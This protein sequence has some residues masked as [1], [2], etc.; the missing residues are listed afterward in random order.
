[1]SASLVDKYKNAEIAVIIPAYRAELFIRRVIT[2]IPEYVKWIVVV[3]DCSPDQTSDVVSAIMDPRVI[4]I[5]HATNQG[6]GGSMWTGYQAA[7]KVGAQ[8]LVKLDADDQ[9]DTR[10]IPDLID[11]IIEGRSDYTKGN[12]FLHLSHIEAMPLIRRLGNIIL[13]FLCKIT[14]GYWS[15]FDPTNG[16][17][18]IHCDIIK[19]FVDNKVNLD[20]R[21]FFE[22]NMLIELSLLRAV[23]MDI[24]IPARYGDEV[25]SLSIPKIMVEFPVKLLKGCTRRILISY[26]VRDFG[27]FSLFLI[28]GIV[29][30]VFGGCFGLYNWIQNAMHQIPTLAGTVMVAVVP[31]ILGVQLLLQALVLDIQNSP[32]AAIHK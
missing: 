6:V 13:S 31:F 14:T 28:T 20:R 23:V 11:P 32:R 5:R 7:C 16:F 10:Y 21:Y 9:M 17:T 26:Y 22:I 25:S 4:L 8:I 30:T 27:A 15:I 1:M 2:A 3:D 19:L 24:H 29:F 12:R 18:A